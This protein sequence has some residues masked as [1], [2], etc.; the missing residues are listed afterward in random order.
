[1]SFEYTRILLKIQLLKPFAICI[2]FT[3][4]FQFTGRT[5]LELTDVGNS[6]SQS[7]AHDTETRHTNIVILAEVITIMKLSVG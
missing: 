6:K 3:T 2:Y 4:F 7:I 1:M 5:Q